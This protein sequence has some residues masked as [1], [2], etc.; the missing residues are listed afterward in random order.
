MSIADISRVSRDDAG[1]L[2]GYQRA[3]VR[4]HIQDITNYLNGDNILFPNS[5]ILA[6]SRR[7]KFRA[8]R[9][10]SVNDGLTTAGILEIPIPTQSGLKPAWVV[11]GQQRLI[12]IKKSKK[13]NLPVPVSA[14]IADEVD[15]QR[16]QFLRVNNTRPLPRGLIT[17]L[18]PEVSTQL[19]AGLEARRIPSAICDLLNRKKESPF[20]GLIRR[21]STPAGEKNK[22]VVTDSSII[23]MIQESFSSP[24]GCLFL[25][26]NIAMGETDV[27]G[28]WQILLT[29]WT[30]V[31]NTFPEAWAKP[32]NKSRLMHGA[33]IRAMGRLM[34][35]VMVFVDVR[36]TRSVK[37]IEHELRRIVRV[38][39]WTGGKWA[40]LGGLNWNDIQNVPR[41]IRILSNLL[42]RAYAEARG[43]A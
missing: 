28:I 25:C 1:K 36:H 7:V 39:H 18:L 37:K 22:A 15:L 31:K 13:H 9:G 34:D 23:R 8:S 21:A 35:R 41:H 14:F 19:P 24:S 16:D 43:G 33:G 3:E 17:E 12:A 32:P 2:I 38:C 6:L 30:A 4:R 27:E 11:D 29:Y 20:Y 5:L 42:L 10:P 40:E 26:R